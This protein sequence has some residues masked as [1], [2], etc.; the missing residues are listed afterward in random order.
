M[1]KYDKII[2]LEY[3]GRQE[4]VLINGAPKMTMYQRA[5]QFAPFAALTGHNEAI[6]EAGRQSASLYD[7]KT[8]D[9]EYDGI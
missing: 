5:A 3:K 7:E 1:G 6:E 2:D 9:G 4:G 8:D